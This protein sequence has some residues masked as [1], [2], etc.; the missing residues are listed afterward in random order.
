MELR[1]S[2]IQNQLI[3][4]VQQWQNSFFIETCPCHYNKRIDKFHSNLCASLQNH[5]KKELHSLC[6]LSKLQDYLVLDPSSFDFIC[7]TNDKLMDNR[8]YFKVRL[9][10]QFFNNFQNVLCYLLPLP[11]SH[12]SMNNKPLVF[13]NTTESTCATHFDRDDSVL[14]VLKGWKQVLLARDSIIKKQYRHIYPFVSESGMHPLILPFESSSK[15]RYAKGWVEVNLKP[16]EAL[17]IPKNVLH[18][19]KSTPG[20]VAISFQITKN[21]C[22]ASARS[23]RIIKEQ[24]EECITFIDRS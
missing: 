24:I 9:G 19:I 8:C 15:Q 22:R 13:Y 14:L 7:S 11:F 20:T 21:E 4:I 23:S 12:Q 1:P 16:N 2:Y 5:I 3:V 17:Y 10:S 6:N 18:T